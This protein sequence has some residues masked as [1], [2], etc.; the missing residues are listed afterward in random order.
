M[1]TGCQIH[2]EDPRSKCRADAAQQTLD[3]YSY[4]TYTAALPISGVHQNAGRGNAGAH[5]DSMLRMQQTHGNRAVQR[6]L[7]HSASAAVNVQRTMVPEYIAEQYAAPQADPWLG[8]GSSAS[9]AGGSLWNQMLGG[10]GMDGSGDEHNVMPVM[11]Q[12]PGPSILDGWGDT[13]GGGGSSSAWGALGGSGPLGAIQRELL[14]AEWEQGGGSSR[15]E[16]PTPGRAPSRSGVGGS[17]IGGMIGKIGRMGKEALDD[18][19]QVNSE[20]IKWLLQPDPM[21]TDC[22]FQP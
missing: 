15:P 4:P 3:A 16:P 10:L 22:G 18:A 7:S 9:G 1:A 19:Q 14:L 21:D 6:S 8:G 12:P 2:G 13:S 17:G 11:T 5:A 20:Y